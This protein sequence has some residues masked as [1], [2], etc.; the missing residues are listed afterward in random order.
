MSVEKGIVHPIPDTREI[1]AEGCFV[2]P[3]L[4]AISFDFKLLDNET[5]TTKILYTAGITNVIGAGID[6]VHQ[7][8]YAQH[9]ATP[10]YSIHARANYILTHIQ[11]ISINVLKYEQG[12]PTIYTSIYD[13]AQ[14]SDDKYKQLIELC[15]DEDLTL[16]VDIDHNPLINPHQHLSALNSFIEKVKTLG[17]C[18]SVF[19]NI[20]H[21]E[22]LIPLRAL[23]DI[24][25]IYFDIRY[26]PNPS[27]TEGLT[28]LDAEQI[29]LALRQ[30]N[31]CSLAV[32]KHVYLSNNGAPDVYTVLSTMN[33]SKPL[34]ITEIIEFAVTRPI[35]LMGMSAQYG[36]IQKGA[37]ADLC[38]WKKPSA[39]S[40]TNSEQT[41]KPLIAVM[42]SGKIVYSPVYEMKSRSARNFFR[43]F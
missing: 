38:I 7:I 39:L 14:M 40:A 20:R 25:D 4:C 37:Y 15:K 42:S 43:G 35:S 11:S 17:L 32:D 24:A 19:T 9:N 33:C 5:D 1:D 13:C 29:T 23:H 41:E 27:Q 10:N 28:S 34:T 18:K 12:I 16:I 2:L 30:S 6:D 8:V 31:K 21:A 3:T 36:K 22:E 26:N